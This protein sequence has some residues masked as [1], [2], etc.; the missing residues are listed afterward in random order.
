MEMK[1][2]QKPIKRSK[3]RRKLG[4]EFYCL[5]ERARWILGEEHWSN[6]LSSERLPFIVKEHRSLLLRK[7][8][9]VDMYLQHNKITNLQLA[10]ERMDGIIIK[11]GQ[12]FSLWKLVG[13][14]TKARGFLEGMTLTNGQVTKGIGGGL[15]QLGN[16]IYW[17]AIHSPLTITK[18]WRHSYDVFPDVN[19]KI[20]FGSGA[21]LSYNYIDLQIK[22]TTDTTY[23]INLWLNNTHLNGNICAALS[24]NFSYTI[25]ERDHRF[26]Q[27]WWG[28]YTRHNEIWRLVTNTLTG[29]ISEELITENHAIMMYNPLIE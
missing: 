14:P 23:Q 2:V 7:L 11:P 27:Q 8:K 20:P 5:K 21:T 3:L 19:R 1:Q 25:Q 15:C 12:S 29:E 13:R 4:K 6:E 24:P 28:G 26:V 17:M 18:R 22:N 16:L 10:I 9:D